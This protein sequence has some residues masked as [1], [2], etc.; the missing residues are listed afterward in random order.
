MLYFLEGCRPFLDTCRLEIRITQIMPHTCAYST[1]GLEY[2][3]FLRNTLP[4]NFLNLLERSCSADTVQIWIIAP[5][6]WRICPKSFNNTCTTCLSSAASSSASSSSEEVCS[7]P[8]VMILP[9]PDSV[10]TIV[11]HYIH[12][13]SPKKRSG[14]NLVWPANIK[15]AQQ[16]HLSQPELSMLNIAPQR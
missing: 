16:F 2:H 5:L 10:S 8:K 13:K 7:Y 6:V 3:A 14:A 1:L 11:F 4:L 12:L 15:K 9:M